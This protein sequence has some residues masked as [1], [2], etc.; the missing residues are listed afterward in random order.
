MANIES[1]ILGRVA[2]YCTGLRYEDLPEGVIAE[3]K[4]CLFD[5]LECCLASIDDK[6]KTGTYN[7]IKKDR[8]GSR[9]TLFGASGLADCEDAAFYNIVTGSISA[10]NEINM[11][12]NGHPG[13]ILIPAAMAV[14]EE[15]DCSGKTL[16]ESIVAAYE[17]S[18]RFGRLIKA[19]KTIP[20]GF[21]RAT[22]SGAY[23]C[24]VAVAKILG[25]GSVET[26]NGAA[27]SLNSLCGLNEWRIPGTG[28][29]VFQ[30]AF[31]ARAG[32]LS[33][34]LAADGV[35]AALGNMDG[36]FGILKIYDMLDRTEELTD[37]LGEQF[38]MLTTKHKPIGACLS[39]QAPCQLAQ[40]FVQEDGILPGE[41]ADITVQV[42]ERLTIL[43]WYGKGEGLDNP[44]FSIMS[45]PFGMAGTMIA[46][47]MAGIDWMPPY[48]D[49]VTELMK[50]I[51][52]LSDDY[53]KEH[54]GGTGFRATVTM[55][56]GTQYIREQF[57]FE[58]L[59]AQQ[60]EELFLYTAERK[61]GSEKARKAAELIHG[62]ENLEHISELTSCLTV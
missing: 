26:A 61:L 15:T 33:A 32:I 35:E 19:S 11:D 39:I 20:A 13:T 36:D 59:N 37:A 38:L 51:H 45:I 7:S 23:G 54:L 22:F 10:R 28:E 30:N 34:K 29:D 52:L 41:I 42:P 50:K 1:T 56:D 2:D 48:S 3:V 46:G 6:R 21:R 9:S 43:P 31:V 12:A 16:I 25:L 24:A 40:Q 53:A 14:G 57:G 17:T 58:P 4:T 18:I 49:A 55:K 62:L 8:Q 47:G 5:A 27:M 60:V 44:V